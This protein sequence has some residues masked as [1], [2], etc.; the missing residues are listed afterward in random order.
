M[1]K[2]Q[3]NTTNTM[4][5]AALRRLFLRSRERAAVMKEAKYCCA[6]CGVKQSKA[7]GK[8]VA[9]HVHHRSG[10][11]MWD[12]MFEVIRA[13]LLNKEDMEV[14]CKDCHDKE[15]KKETAE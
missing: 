3:P 8:E 2:K 9:V 4:I 1:G 14:L 10:I 15:H 13:E 7:K 11:T 12:K 6:T 5:R